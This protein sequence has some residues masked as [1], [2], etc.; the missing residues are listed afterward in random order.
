MSLIYLFL[1]FSGTS[2]NDFG[3]GGRNSDVDSIVYQKCTHN[4]STT[5]PEEKN[6]QLL[7]FESCR[8]SK[9]C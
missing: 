2:F 1:P 5:T 9:N 6:H 3:I 8:V 7:L 4:K